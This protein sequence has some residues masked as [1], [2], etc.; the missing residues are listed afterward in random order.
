MGEEVEGWG[1]HVRLILKKDVL[2]SEFI[3][4]NEIPIPGGGQ[5]KSG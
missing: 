4:G 3:D 2:K 1:Q 5:M